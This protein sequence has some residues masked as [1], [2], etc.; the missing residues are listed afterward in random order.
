MK[1]IIFNSK[2]GAKFYGT[3]EAMWVNDELFIPLKCV[4]LFKFW[5]DEDSFKWVAIAPNF[6]WAYVTD[7]EDD[8]IRYLETSVHN[9]ET[10]KIIGGSDS[11]PDLEGNK[12]FEYST[13][14]SMLLK[15]KNK[16]VGN[17]VSNELWAEYWLEG[18][19]F[20]AEGSLD[21][22]YS[23]KEMSQLEDES[24]VYQFGD[25]RKQDA[26]KP[27]NFLGCLPF[28]F[29]ILLAMLAQKCDVGDW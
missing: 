20:S 5:K 29:G 12:G 4:K 8:F 23:A 24:L 28:I 3:P 18:I 9:T 19:H 22:S 15:F 10:H 26:K 13:R 21:K 27:F 16:E 6:S 25:F 17:K 2:S 1:R 11:F 14:Q 7:E